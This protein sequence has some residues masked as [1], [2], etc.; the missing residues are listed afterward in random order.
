MRVSYYCQHVL[1]IGHFHRSLE[2]CRTC[3]TDHEMTMIVGGPELDIEEPGIRFLQLPGLRMDQDFLAL[4]PCDPAL[5]LDSVKRKRRE[6]L[7]DFILAE[8]PDCLIVEL[9]PFGRKNFRFE[10]DP[11]LE[12]LQD[13]GTCKIYCSLRDILVE[14]KEGL[15]KFEN[16]IVDTLNRYFDGLFV[17]GDQRFITLERT[18]SQMSRVSVPVHYTGFVTPKPTPLARARIRG[19]TG[20]GENQKLVVASI[21]SGSV[22]AELLH[23]VADAARYLTNSGNWSFHLFAGPYL[24]S[25]TF[26]A[27]RGKQNEFLKVHR[28]S[29][30]FIDWLGAA[31]L[32]IS[33]AGYNTS[34]NILA[35][36]VPALLYPFSQNREQ[37]M[38]IDALAAAGNVK[39]IT[40]DDLD[41]QQ[42]ARLIV[43][44]GSWQRYE[45]D[46]DL[47]GALATKYLIEHLEK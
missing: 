29:D 22:G 12:G 14:K 46:I 25:A 23:G 15:E 19:E 38:R 32:S 33:M 21:G 41:P 18:F 35:A 16:R 17:H 4:T 5:D 44:G 28:F 31:D 24:D 1:G 27:L 6:M 11:L 39:P 45:P 7:L 2:I 8:P 9:Y 20:L 30:R 36:G 34:M 10:L 26:K 40:R 47:N 3:G 42:L 43:E 13:V 37:R